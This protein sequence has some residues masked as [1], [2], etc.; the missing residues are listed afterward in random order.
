MLTL[1]Y[2]RS[3]R[4]SRRAVENRY[5]RM[6]MSEGLQVIQRE[7]VGTHRL[8][9]QSCFDGTNEGKAPLLLP[10]AVVETLAPEGYREAHIPRALNIP[11]VGSEIRPLTKSGTCYRSCLPNKN[12]EFMTYCTNTH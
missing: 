1:I 12:A 9:Q 5:V 4:S 11:L 2:Q 7:L 3:R 8:W 6:P 10:A